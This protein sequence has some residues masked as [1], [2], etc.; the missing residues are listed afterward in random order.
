MVWA[1]RTVSVRRR[2]T[3]ET[4]RDIFAAAHPFEGG[5]RRGHAQRR[6][7]RLNGCVPDHTA[8]GGEIRLCLRLRT[9]PLDGWVP[10]CFTLFF[11]LRF[12]FVNVCFLFARR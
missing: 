4:G 6:N 7:G 5:E 8:L 10:G 3:T 11:A 2:E 9:Y 1:H 12:L